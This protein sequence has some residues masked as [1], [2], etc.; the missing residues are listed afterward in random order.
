MKKIIFTP[1]LLLN[2]FFCPAQQQAYLNFYQKYD[3]IPGE[4]IIF[5]DDFSSD[6]NGTVPLHWKIAQ[7]KAT[8]QSSEGVNTLLLAGT[9]IASVEPIIGKATFG[10]A[11]T[12]E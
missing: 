9:E 1:L 8:I 7:G 4:N 10:A 5:E 2:I 3:F 11:F 12:I 6:K